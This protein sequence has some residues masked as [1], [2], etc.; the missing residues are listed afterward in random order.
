L[1]TVA[2]TGCMGLVMY[3]LALAEV[4]IAIKQRRHVNQKSLHGG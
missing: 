1:E 4:I 2:A 3:Y